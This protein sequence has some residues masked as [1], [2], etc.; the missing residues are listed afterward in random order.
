MVNNNYKYWVGKLFL[1]QF[2]SYQHSGIRLTSGTFVTQKNILRPIA[3]A[4]K[5]AK[6]RKNSK[7]TEEQQ[8]YIPKLPE[9][10]LDI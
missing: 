8:K 3:Q 10:G 4:K 6:T 2:S 7:I 5:T 1:T 9:A